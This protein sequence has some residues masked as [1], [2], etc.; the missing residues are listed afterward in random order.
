M[1]EDDDDPEPED[2]EPEQDAAE[3]DPEASEEEPE[4]IRKTKT[5]EPKRIEIDDGK[6]RALFEA[7]RP[8]SWIA[9]DMDISEPTVRSHLKKMGLWPRKD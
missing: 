7:E 6:I 9:E 2:A 3:A 4:Q 8:I 1:I 5:K